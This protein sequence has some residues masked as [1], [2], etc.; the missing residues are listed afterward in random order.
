MTAIFVVAAAIAQTWQE[1]VLAARQAL[2]I[3]VT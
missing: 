2:G 1:L 3:T